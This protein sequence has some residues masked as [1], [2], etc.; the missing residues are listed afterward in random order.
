MKDDVSGG[1]ILALVHHSKVHFDI[2]NMIAVVQVEQTFHNDTDRYLEGVYAFPLPGNA[3]LGQLRSQDYFNIIKCNSSHRE[4]YHEPLPTN[5][6]FTQRAQEFVQRLDA[7]GGTEVLSALRAA[8]SRPAAIDFKIDWGAS[9]DAWP[10]RIPDLYQGEVLLVVARFG[11]TLPPEDI[12]VSGRVNEWAWQQQ[13]QLTNELQPGNASVHSG[14]ASVWAR[15][16]IAG[17]L[18]Q[19]IAG[20]DEAAVCADVLPLALT[21]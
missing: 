11:T 14:V 8:L 18:D 4:L 17:L 16:K 21:H 7:S 9:V 5:A 2:N 12:T 20:R 1:Y 13:L 10:Q 3:A 6:Q 15:R 19:N